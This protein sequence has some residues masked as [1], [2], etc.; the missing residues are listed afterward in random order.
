M[1]ETDRFCKVTKSNLQVMGWVAA[2][3]N[4]VHWNKRSF[5]KP[6]RCARIDSFLAPSYVNESMTHFADVNKLQDCDVTCEVTRV[7][8]MNRREEYRANNQEP[9]SA[10]ADS[11]VLEGRER[12]GLRPRL[13]SPS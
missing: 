8:H 5:L 4:N 10:Y 6:M 1:C 12:V 7:Y 11:Y 13:H 9:D 2:G 3:G